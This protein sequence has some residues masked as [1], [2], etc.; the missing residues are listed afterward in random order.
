M[1]KVR[2]PPP[3]AQC[4]PHRGIRARAR[5]GEGARAGASGE[6]RRAP[7]R[8]ADRP[9]P[10]GPTKA[11]GASSE[12]TAGPRSRDPGGPRRRALAGGGTTD[13]GPFGVLGRWNGPVT[14]TFSKAGR[15]WVF[16]VGPGLG[17]TLRV[18]RLEK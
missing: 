7:P 6:Q 13:P 15:F 2:D 11:P 9:L 18:H 12:A 8:E 14:Q 1:Q 4:P 17:I 16:G 3:P 5:V 10:F